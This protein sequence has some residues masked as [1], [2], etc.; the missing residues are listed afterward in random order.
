[1][2]GA[3]LFMCMTWAALVGGQFVGIAKSKERNV[4]YLA[5]LFIS[6]LLIRF[7]EYLSK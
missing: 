1:M 6:S 5:I 2:S 7:G 4:G 3:T